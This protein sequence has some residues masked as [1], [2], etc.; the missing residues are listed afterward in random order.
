[1]VLIPAGGFWMGSAGEEGQ[2]DERPRRW[3][4]LESFRID[5]H[6]VTAAQ[7][8]EFCREIGREPPRQPGWSTPDHPVVN[9]SWHDARDYASWAGKRL[10][11]EAEWE[12]AARGGT[13]TRYSFGDDESLLDRFAWFKGNSDDQAHAVGLKE[14]NPFG[15]HDMHGNVWEWVEDRYAAGPCRVLRGGSWTTFDIL[16]RSAV[17]NWL[18]PELRGQNLGLRCC[19]SG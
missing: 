19:A 13:G 3:V 4:H 11:T 10:P 5:V 14:P 18:L 7:F 2:E 9:V 6:P 12:K 15:L 17:R 8:M 16:C 1:M